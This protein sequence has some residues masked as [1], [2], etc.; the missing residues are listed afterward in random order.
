MSRRLKPTLLGAGR[1]QALTTHRCLPQFKVLVD[2]LRG[3]GI[4]AK[5]P[6][7][8]LRKEFGSLICQEAGIF[9]ASAQ[10]RHSS[11]K[12]TNEYYADKKSKTTVRVGKMLGREKP[13]PRE[14]G[15]T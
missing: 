7:H 14:E 10:L 3:K 13:R 1:C 11:I 8:T 15:F 9:A 2:W 6:L 4:T 12:L 5:K